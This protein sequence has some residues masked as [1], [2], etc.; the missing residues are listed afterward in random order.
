M[1]DWI[2]TLLF[3]ALAYLFGSIPTGY[4]IVKAKK[5]IDIRKVGSGATGGTNVARVLGKKWGYLVGILDGLKAFLPVFLAKKILPQ[6]TYYHWE[7]V[8]VALMPVI[9]H[10]WSIFLNFK[11]GKGVA[12][13]L[14]SLLALFG[15]KVLALPFFIMLP[16][17]LIFKISSIASLTLALFL[18]LS[19]YFFSQGKQEYLILGFLLLVIIFW[20]HRENIQRL[21]QGKEKRSG[22]V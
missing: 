16:L 20:S 15:W 7:L 5:G 1:S 22:L 9:G 4:L 21:I 19:L 3:C 2:L 8:F 11:A 17:I 14:G 13:T 18:P 12:S 10:I 6:G